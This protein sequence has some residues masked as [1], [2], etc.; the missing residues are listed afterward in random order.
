VKRRHLLVAIAALALGAVSLWLARRLGRPGAGVTAAPTADG[1]AHSSGIFPASDQ[2][3]AL[4]LADA[5]VPRFGP[6][7]AA[8]EID[9]LPRV[10]RSLALME[11]GELVRSNWSA[12]AAALRASIPRNPAVDPEKLRALL[13][14][15]YRQARRPDP[16]PEAVCF[17]ALRCAVLRAYYTS[18]EGWRAAGYPGPVHRTHPAGGAGG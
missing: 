6:H 7:P 16:R 9:L 15:W 12:L 5:I 1:S 17:E 2:A 10:E 4:A 8:S 13:E 3:L 14:V 18:P 11:T